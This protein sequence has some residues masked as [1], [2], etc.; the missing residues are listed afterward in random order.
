MP[1]AGFSRQKIHFVLNLDA[2]GKLTGVTDLRQQEGKKLVPRELVVPE[3]VKRSVG[4]TA[5]FLWDNTGYVLGADDKGKPE[6]SA[7]TF[8]AFKTL[9]HAIGDGLDDAG[10]TCVRRWRRRGLIRQSAFCIGTGRG[11]RD[12]PWI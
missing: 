1:L 8:A 5:N 6:R 10:M 4:I 11:G 12:W 2:D 3:A 7:K 9:C